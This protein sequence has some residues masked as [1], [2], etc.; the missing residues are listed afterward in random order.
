MAHSPASWEEN[1]IKTL[2]ELLEVY[3]YIYII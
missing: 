1:G 2:I 3:I